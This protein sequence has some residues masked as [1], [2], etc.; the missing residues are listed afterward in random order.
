MISS[1]LHLNES[2]KPYVYRWYQA[3]LLKVQNLIVDFEIVIEIMFRLGL[4]LKEYYYY[5]W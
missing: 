3:I 4:Y 1:T 5:W 2:V